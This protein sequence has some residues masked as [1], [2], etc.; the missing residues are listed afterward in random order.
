[1]PADEISDPSIAVT[2][3]HVDSTVILNRSIAQ[4]GRLP[5][6]DYIHSSS[7]LLKQEIIGA[8]HYSTV[9]EATDVLL[10]HEKLSRIV[11]IV[12]QDEL[13]GDNRTVFERGQKILNYL[14]QPFFSAEIQTGRKGVFVPREKT[15]RDIRKILSGGADKLP[16]SALLYIGSLEDLS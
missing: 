15:I 4:Q 2:I 9:I 12:G 7:A 14:T 6:V 5:A 16:T 10:Q 13:S 3:P 11:A 1:L 8:E